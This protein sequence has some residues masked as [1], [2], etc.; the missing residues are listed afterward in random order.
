MLC[1]LYDSVAKLALVERF[2]YKNVMDIPKLVKV[3]VNVGAGGV[4][5]KA[6]E[7]IAQNVAVLTGQKAKITFARKS[8]AGF[9]LRAKQKIGCSVTLRSKRMYH[10][11]ERSLYFAFPRSRDFRGF[12]I[13]QFDGRGNFNIGVKEHTV[14]PEI[15]YSKVEKIF[16]MDIN[17]VT[18]AKSDEEGKFLLTLLDFPFGD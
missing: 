11:L 7:Y 12:S 8:I 10:F 16:G 2:G 13:R 1:E 15:D 6:I 3:C 9:K 18:T 5:N 17:I 4:D 14:Y